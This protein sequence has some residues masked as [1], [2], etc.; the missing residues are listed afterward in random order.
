VNL[1]DSSSAPSGYIPRA[2]RYPIQTP[3]R[4]R[5]R[6]K[7]DWQEGT[8]LNISRTGVLFQSEIDLPPKTLIE[9]QIALPHDIVGEPTANVL[10]WGPVVRTDQLITEKS[11]QPALAAAILRY[12]FSHD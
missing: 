7:A 10:C 2:T 6:G 11:G 8:T 4:F 1:E 12:R 3:V 9:M 5:E